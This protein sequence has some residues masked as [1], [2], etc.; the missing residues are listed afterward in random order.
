MKV[1]DGEV[2]KLSEFTL[3]DYTYNLPAAT[4]TT[5]G[6]VK[7]GINIVDIANPDNATAPQVAGVVNTLLN[8]LRAAGILIS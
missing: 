8:Q 1:T 7:A 5:L 2:S 3:K 4:K 6:G